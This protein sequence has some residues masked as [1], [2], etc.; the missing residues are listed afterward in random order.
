MSVRLCYSFEHNDHAA[1]PRSLV[2]VPPPGWSYRPARIRFDEARGRPWAHFD[3]MPGEIIH[4]SS[5]IPTNDCPFVFDTDHAEYLV[6]QSDVQRFGS[7]SA[8]ERE[9]VAA[10][11]SPLCLRLIAWS[12]AA[13][14]SLLELFARQAVKP[15]RI[16]VLF[17]CVTPPHSDD[18]RNQSRDTLVDPNEAA[19]E[20]YLTGLR[21]LPTPGLV[22][23]LIVDGQIGVCNSPSRKNVRDAVR[24]FRELRR[25]DLPVELVIVGSAEPVPAEPG[26]VALPALRR[27][28]LWKLYQLVDV[29][30][31]L[32]RQDSF[33]FVLMEAMFHGLACVAGRARSAPALRELIQ[34]G[35]SGYLVPFRDDR[36]FPE[37]S[38]GLDEERL[39]EVVHRLVVDP[40]VRKRLRGEC[41]ALFAPGGAFSMELRDQ[42]LARALQLEP[43]SQ[44]SMA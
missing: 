25:R 22:R 36:P 2:Q 19:D 40:E 37:L 43:Q 28:T 3:A 6:L 33:G 29:L 26:I 10:L 13:R 15:P 16:D 20:R 31:Y 30:L 41:R 32:S 14:E 21:N 9:L 18:D 34:D 38:D 7:R 39:H 24:C 8:V 23:L 35:L 11:S 12:E 4:A 17:P 44:V 1:Y 42:R 27:S 5:L